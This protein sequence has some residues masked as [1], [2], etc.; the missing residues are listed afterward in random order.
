M[1]LK[2]SKDLYGR[3]LVLARSNRHVDLNLL[4]NIIN[5]LK[6]QEFS[7]LPMKMHLHGS[8]KSKLIH[9]LGKLSHDKERM[10]GDDNDKLHLKTAD[11][12]IPLQMVCIVEKLLL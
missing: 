9:F 11:V 2:E 7:F 4:F 6:H 10:V 3:L 12:M 1:D 8:D 5:S